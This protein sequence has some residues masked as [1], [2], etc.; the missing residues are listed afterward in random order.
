MVYNLKI[1]RKHKLGQR[2]SQTPLSSAYW[3]QTILDPKKCWT[4]PTWLALTKPVL[5]N[6][7]LKG[8]V[9]TWPALTWPVLTWPVLTWPVLEHRLYFI[10][11]FVNVLNCYNTKIFYQF[12][13]IYRK[14]YSLEHRLLF[15]FRFV[16]VLNG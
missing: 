4:V 7:L 2:Q 10:F 15:I 5:N 3:V 12:S 11:R 8:T 1:Y 13:M 14:D 6:P 9:L 16:Q